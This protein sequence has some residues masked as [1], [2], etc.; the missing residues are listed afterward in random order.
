MTPFDAEHNSEALGT[1]YTLLCNKWN[2][3]ALS[4]NPDFQITSI[5]MFWNICLIPNYFRTFPQQMSVKYNIA[6]KIQ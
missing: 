3:E 4:V 5:F 2:V 6:Y 1:Q